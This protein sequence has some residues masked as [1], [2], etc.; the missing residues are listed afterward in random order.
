MGIKD[1]QGFATFGLVIAV[2]VRFERQ[3]DAIA[4]AFAMLLVLGVVV[5]IIACLLC[6]LFARVC[7]LATGFGSKKLAKF[8][9][10]RMID[11][12]APSA[13]MKELE[14]SL[15]M[16]TNL[17]DRSPMED[18]MLQDVQRFIKNR[19]QGKIEPG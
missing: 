15:T 5:T 9:T 7:K 3:L 1:V 18:L 4:D 17:Q 8:Q 10:I 12:P 19:Q 14:A 13:P 6:L 16:L 11:S 2:I